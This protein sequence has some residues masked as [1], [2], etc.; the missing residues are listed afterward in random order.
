MLERILKLAGVEWED[1]TVFVAILLQV[2]V[3]SLSSPEAIDW[4]LLLRKWW[5]CLLFKFTVL[6]SFY[7]MLLIFCTLR[8]IGLIKLSNIM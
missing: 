8:L 5:V 2:V 4:P 6:G 3:D 1:E 7:S